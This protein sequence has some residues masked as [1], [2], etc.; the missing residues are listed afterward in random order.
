MLIITNS[1][2]HILF[3]Y[4]SGYLLCQATFQIRMNIKDDFVLV[5]TVAIGIQEHFDQAR[6]EAGVDEET[7]NIVYLKRLKE[8]HVYVGGKQCIIHRHCFKLR[9]IVHVIRSKTVSHEQ[10]QIMQ[11][12]LKDEVF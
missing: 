4:I 3:L 10:V 8:G 11:T 1:V 5:D 7:F 9:S 6:I 12:L 2:I